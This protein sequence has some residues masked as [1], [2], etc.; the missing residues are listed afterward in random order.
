MRLVTV[1][2]VMVFGFC[3]TLTFASSDKVYKS[4]DANGRVVYSQSP[5]AANAVGSASAAKV[6]E[7]NNLPA[8][9]LSAETLKFRA[10]MEKNIAT[11][12]AAG[13]APPAYAGAVLYSAKWCGYCKVAKAYLQK[14]GHAYQELDIDT[15]EGMRSFVQVLP[16]SGIPVL[17]KD[18]KRLNGF[19]QQAYDQFFKASR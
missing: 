10:D 8:S 6:M 4:V 7:F 12:A 1:L 18:G 9:P 16:K 3:A 17:I 11:K 19:N 14:G 2:I 5:P 15:P 13:F